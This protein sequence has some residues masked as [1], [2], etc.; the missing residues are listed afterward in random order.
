MKTEYSQ[1]I[2]DLIESSFAPSTPSDASASKKTLNEIHESVI[3]VL[4]SK[5]IYEEDVYNVLQQL[6]YRPFPFTEESK[7]TFFYYLTPIN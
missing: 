1:E 3:G 5:W 2:K 6:N 7:T 4:P